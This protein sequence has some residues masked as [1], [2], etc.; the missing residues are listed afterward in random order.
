MIFQVELQK[1][2]VTNF[3][4]KHLKEK[5]VGLVLFSFTK[6][7]CVVKSLFYTL[8]F[9]YRNIFFR[10][11][12]DVRK[13][14]LSTRKRKLETICSHHSHPHTHHQ[15]NRASNRKSQEWLIKENWIMV[16]VLAGGVNIS[17]TQQVASLDL[18]LL[19]T[20]MEEQ[21]YNIILL[22]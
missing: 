9:I 10:K 8:L 18:P 4:Q 21:V 6:V 7:S 2:R 5:L 1:H 3:E 13:R 16:V 15:L 19:P 14:S 12:Q 11:M 20:S 17:E 22:Y